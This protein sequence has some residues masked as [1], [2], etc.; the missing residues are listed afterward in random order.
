MHSW[1]DELTQTLVEEKL[2]HRQVIR[3]I[4]GTIIA[5]GVSNNASTARHPVIY[6]VQSC[7]T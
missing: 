2:P 4:S 3:R 6:R 1:F 5:N 7:V